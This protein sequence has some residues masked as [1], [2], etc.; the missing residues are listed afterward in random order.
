[1]TYLVGALLYSRAQPC[2]ARVSAR[3]IEERTPVH[4]G[5]IEQAKDARSVDRREGGVAVPQ[6]YC[7]KQ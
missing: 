6:P 7:S 3:G 4:P 1:V 2:K 5:D